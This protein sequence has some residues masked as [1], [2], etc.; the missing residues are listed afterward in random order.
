M[1]QVCLLMRTLW[2]HELH[3]KTTMLLNVFS[4]WIAD[5]GVQS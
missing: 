3:L 4:V 1:S 5:I 2:G